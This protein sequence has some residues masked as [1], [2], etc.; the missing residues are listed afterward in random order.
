MTQNT[1]KAGFSRDHFSSQVQRAGGKGPIRSLDHF[2]KQTKFVSKNNTS[3]D[4]AIKKLNIVNVSKPSII[5]FRVEKNYQTDRR[6]NEPG[7]FSF[8]F[9]NKETNKELW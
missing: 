3:K 6:V 7:W 5:N 4:I 2:L 9:K 1:S 8:N